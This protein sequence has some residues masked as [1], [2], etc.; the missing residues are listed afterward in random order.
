MC[1]R[2]DA[3]DPIGVNNLISILDI[4]LPAE[5]F[6][7]R[8]NIAPGAQLA[9]VCYE[10]GYSIAD[11][12]WGLLPSWAKADMR[13]LINARAETIHEKPSFKKL[14]RHTRCIVPVNGFYEWQRSGASKR[15]YHFSST[16]E[17]ALA[18]GAIYQ[19]ESEGKSQCCIVTTAANGIMAAVHD[20]MPVIIARDAMSDWLRS[21]D[22]AMIDALMQPCADELLQLHEVSSYANNARNEGERCITPV[23]AG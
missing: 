16:D 10:N 9:A 22:D 2:I 7:P 5:R 14:V 23:H 12:I 20:R 11:M 15:S 21:E 13:P 17:N 1:G 18:L 19:H 4:V 6:P 3:H 8:Y